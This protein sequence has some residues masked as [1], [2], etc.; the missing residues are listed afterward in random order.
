MRLPQRA[1]ILQG[2]HLLSALHRP[3]LC[4][5]FT[6]RVTPFLRFSERPRKTDSHT[7]KPKNN[8]S[9]FAKN[10]RTFSEKSRDLERFSS[11]FQSRNKPKST[12]NKSKQKNSTRTYARISKFT[13]LPSPL[14]LSF[15]TSLIQYIRCEHKRSIFLHL[16]TS[17]ADDSKEEI[18]IYSP[19]FVD[20]QNAQTHSVNILP[21]Y[22][23]P[24][25]II[26]QNLTPQ[27]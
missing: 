13:F 16:C 18:L 5:I 12:H 19:Y 17:P 9:I 26:F 22:L 3:P 24:Q 10:K 20:S 23:H 21:L 11:C 6:G 14:H 2:A 27:R 7:G 4:A 8:P 25:P 15:Y 1:K